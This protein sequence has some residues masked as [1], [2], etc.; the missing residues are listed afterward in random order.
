M[1]FARSGKRTRVCGGESP[2]WADDRFCPTRRLN[3]RA[4]K[5]AHICACARAYIT[6]NT[7]TH[8]ER[9]REGDLWVH[10]LYYILVF[11]YNA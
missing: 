5:N 1:S 6:H 10:L 2:S 8:T 7:H 4:K 9:E 3:R 11:A